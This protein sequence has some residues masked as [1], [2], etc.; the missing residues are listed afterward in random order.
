MT[1]AYEDIFESGGKNA[2]RV[3]AASST[4]TEAKRIYKERNDEFGSRARVA[5]F[6]TKP[7]HTQTYALKTKDGGVLTIAPLSHKKETLVTH[8]GLE[9]R[10]SSVEAIYNSRR[11][12][13]VVTDF[14]GQGLFN[15]PANGKPK[16][17][18]GVYTVIDSR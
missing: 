6:E 15:L 4:L 7:A 1:H 12:P 9:I 8:S 10:P 14:H 16:A 5:F 11:R 13:I 17:L 3:F 2:G 18:D